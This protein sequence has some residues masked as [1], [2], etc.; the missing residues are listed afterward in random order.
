[1]AKAAG[2]SGTPLVRKLGL[3]PGMR[4]CFVSA[5]KA[6]LGTTLE[7]PPDVRVLA[8]PGADMD[9]V[10]LFVTR[11]DKLEKELA[12]LQPKLATAGALWIS[13]PKGKSG[14]DTDLDGNV[15]RT[16]GLASGLVDIK[17]CAVDEIWSGLKFVRRRAD[18]K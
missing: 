4:A 18:R 5:P 12:R 1:M 9:F 6:Y 10:Q 3:K 15:V 8:R 17:V 11:R 7:L 13:W 2:Y 16:T 14:V